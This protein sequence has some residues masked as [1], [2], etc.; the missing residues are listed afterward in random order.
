[1]LTVL[2]AAIVMTTIVTPGVTAGDIT[3]GMIAHWKLDEPA[4]STTAV[5][6]VGGFNGTIAANVSPGT[7]GRVDGAF[8]FGGVNPNRVLTTAT[9]GNLNLNAGPFSM[10]AF[11]KTGSVGSTQRHIISG[12]DGA[13]NRWNLA[14]SGTA[15][16]AGNLLWFHNGGINEVVTSIKVD[17][18]QYH[19]VGISKDASNNYTAYVDSQTV[20]LGTDA[21]ALNNSVIALG[22]RPNNSGFP[23]AGIIDDVRIYS[24]VLAAE[25]IQDLL[26]QPFPIP[27]PAVGLLAVVAISFCIANGRARI[28][29]GTLAES[30]N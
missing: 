17:D 12:N 26:S 2:F 30:E 24:R 15:G 19:L 3:T 25:D 7:V 1:M 10:F 14:I 18:D 9:A 29:N 13:A 28:A 16:V 21:V 11:V 27:E 22:Q 6:S 4:G 23:L 8:T 20:S 5:D